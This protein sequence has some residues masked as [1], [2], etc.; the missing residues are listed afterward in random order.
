[1]AAEEGLRTET[2]KKR[3]KA[4]RGKGTKKKGKEKR[5]REGDDD[6]FSLLQG[7]PRHVPALS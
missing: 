1:M 4:V 3:N 6:E 2:E 7:R 5:V